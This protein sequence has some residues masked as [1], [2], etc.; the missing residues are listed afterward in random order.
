MQIIYAE[1]EILPG[2]P[3]VPVEGVSP[4]ESIHFLSA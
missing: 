3:D 2:R 4:G 1:R